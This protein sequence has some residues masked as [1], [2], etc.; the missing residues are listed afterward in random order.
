MTKPRIAFNWASSC[1]G[2]EIA[3]LELG[4]KLVEL[5][6]KIDIVFWPVALDF[7]YSDLESMSD[8]NIDVTF[9]NGAIQTSENLHLAQLLRAK[10]K[11]LVAFGACAIMGGIPALAN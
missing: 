7:K 2:C 8:K 4:T 1:G 11:L 9:F 10:S 3:V 5:N 6:D